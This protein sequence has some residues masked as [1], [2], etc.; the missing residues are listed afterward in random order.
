MPTRASELLRGSVMKN[1]MKNWWVAVV[2]LVAVLSLVPLDG[3]VSEAMARGGSHGGG[4]YKGGHGK[5]GDVGVR[6]YTR[7]DG[8]YVQPHVRSAP[9]STRLDN[10]STKGNVNR[11]HVSAG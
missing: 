9:N 6:G 2:V 11:G 5:G 8:T 7:R 4:S 1:V 3:F 10:F